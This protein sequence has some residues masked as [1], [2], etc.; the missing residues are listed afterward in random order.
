METRQILHSLAVVSNIPATCFENGDELFRVPELSYLPKLSSCELPAL[1]EKCSD[2]V[3]AACVFTDEL[4]C[5]GLVRLTDGSNFDVVFGPVSA[6]DCDNRR[7]QRILKRYGLPS[8][9]AGLLLGYFNEAATCTLLRF[10]ELISLAN[11]TLNREMVDIVYLLPEDYRMEEGAIRSPA[12]MPKLVNTPH[13]A[14]DYE[15]QMYSMLRFGQYREM[16]SF[17]SNSTFTGNQGTLAHNLLRHQKNMVISSATIAARAAVDGGL[18]YDT[19]M[20]VADHYIQ[21]VELACD[22]SALM[23]LHK[24]MLKAFTRMVA[25][26]RANNADSALVNKV[27]EY[28]ELHLT[29]PIN[30]Q[31]VAAELGMN[32]TYLSAQFKREC[33]IGLN[34]YINRMKID[35]ATRLLVTTDRSLSDIASL[36]AFSSQSHFQS[37]FKKVTG[38]TPGEYRKNT[39]SG[40]R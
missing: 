17:L 37:V 5:Y 19:A 9:E 23:I 32:R 14:R 40:T 10:S 22:R 6:I 18:D 12:L 15:R 38:M 21:Q 36:L 31:S 7:A 20:S 29:Q 11:Y 25:E 35:E 13:D 39:Y 27:T 30:V 34:D 8:T 3:H 24:N 33:G 28:I 4:L 26:K 16:V 1:K 2:G